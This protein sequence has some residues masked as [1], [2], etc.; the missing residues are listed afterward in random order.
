MKS[1]QAGRW[2]LVAAVIVTM[3]AACGGGGGGSAE[4]PAQPPPPSGPRAQSLAV[5]RPGELLAYVQ[6]RLRARPADS[7]SAGFV[8]SSGPPT[9]AA[10]P[11]G[12]AAATTPARSGTLVQESGVDEADL[13]LSDGTHLYTLQPG[14]DGA[15]QLRVYRRSTG[16]SQDLKRL[17]L[18]DPVAT[19]A[20]VRG[21]H[22]STDG[23]ALAT[24][25]SAWESLPGDQTCK[26]G[27]SIV[28]LPTL[29]WI[30]MRNT[31]SVHRVDVSDPANASAGTHLSIEG[32]FVDSRR[33]G[34]TL[35]LVSTHAPRL[36]LD[37][38]P[39]TATAAEREAAIQ[40]LTAGELLPKLRRNGGPAEPLLG[41]TDCFL[42]T[43]NASTGVQITSVTMID[44]KSATLA[45]KSRCIVGGT[46][47]LYMTAEHLYLATTRQ[48]YS[49][50]MPTVLIYPQTMTT[51]IHKFALGAADV[52]YRGSG[53]VNGHLGW[54]QDRKSYRMSEHNGDL[55]V[56]TYTGSDG[57]FS[58]QDAASK[59][60]SP[61]TLTVL[62]E[63]ASDQSLQP[64]ATLPNTSRPAALGKAGE[65]VYA[66]RF[67]GDRAYLVTFR[68]ADPLYVLDLSNPADP[69]AVGELTVAGFSEQLYPLANGLLLGVGRDADDKGV[70][71]GIKL[72]LF[73]VADPARPSQRA[74]FVMGGMF[75]TSAADYSR[76]GLNLF[77][78]GNVA[79]IAL[80]VNLAPPGP[81]FAPNGWQAGL[82]RFEVDTDAR[83]MRERPMV[84]AVNGNGER[85]PWLE[86]S[87]Q[88][89]DQVFYLGA[90]ELGAYAW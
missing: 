22:A 43:A 80:P 52:V 21:M 16:A 48:T 33:I 57:W 63:R 64:L 14:T 4:P 32:N 13:L 47:A 90:G 18:V 19:G 26:T 74:S 20:N 89:E 12:S 5:S 60:A 10:Q 66:V 15:T 44:L 70:V 69:K 71:G 23:K 54:D 35:Y 41:D 50:P 61:A 3:L 75:S 9:V 42:Q 73:D 46:E 38:L 49:F 87:L 7:A 59:P 77:M 31:V 51:D 24:V 40:Q 37:V 86:R 2:P 81:T 39:A 78:R 67:V 27:C 30:W 84:G 58:I 79:R 83:T 72:A 25:G 29:P 82:A 88:I 55:R 11:V 45:Q 28:G 62:R 65:Q 53:V 36:P 34:D 76:H 56:L 85:N 6:Q 68:R 8:I 17:T 1:N